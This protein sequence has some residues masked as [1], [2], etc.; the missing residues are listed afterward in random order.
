MNATDWVGSL[1]VALLLL[2]F[3]L[4]LKNSISKN[5]LAYLLLN[6]TGAALACLASVWL[7][8]WPFILLEAC[9]TLVSL[10]SLLH[11]FLQKNTDR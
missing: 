5:G 10:H 9:W 8:Y 11:Y 3:F 1:G 6:V 4:Q 7:N 2:A